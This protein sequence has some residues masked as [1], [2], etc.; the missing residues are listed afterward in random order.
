[1]LVMFRKVINILIIVRDE[2]IG[3]VNRIIFFSVLI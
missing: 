2:K 3:S 1:M